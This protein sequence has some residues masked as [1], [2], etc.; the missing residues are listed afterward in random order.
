ME[1]YETG[2]VVV[3]GRDDEAQMDVRMRRLSKPLS[4]GQCREEGERERLNQQATEAK[5]RI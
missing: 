3:A 1:I 2:E 5:D 4:S